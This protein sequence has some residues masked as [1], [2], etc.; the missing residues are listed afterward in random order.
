METGSVVALRKP[1]R[2]LPNGFL[3]LRDKQPLPRVLPRGLWV[4]LKPWP[5]VLTRLGKPPHGPWRPAQHRVQTAPACVLCGFPGDAEVHR[6]FRVR[7]GCWS[8]R[9]AFENGVWAAGSG[10]SAICWPDSARL[11]AAAQ[12]AQRPWRVPQLAACPAGF[13][14]PVLET[15]SRPGCPGLAPPK[16]SLLGV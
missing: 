9:L 5:L 11:C 4:W 7:R 15:E 12:S 3:C 10:E 2:N 16:A 8:S 1:A 6:P 13:T 14:V